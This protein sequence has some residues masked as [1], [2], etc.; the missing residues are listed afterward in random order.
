MWQVLSQPVERVGSAGEGE[1][2][3]GEEGPC[4]PSKEVGLCSLGKGEP[5]RILRRARSLI[6]W[7]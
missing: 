3:A 5:R 4:Q 6:G 2:K 1:Q 7:P